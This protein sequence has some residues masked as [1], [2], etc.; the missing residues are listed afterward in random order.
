MIA[1][2]FWQRM[3]NQAHSGKET[4]QALVETAITLP[5]LVLLLLGAVELGRVAYAAVEVANSARAAAQYGAMNG[6]AIGD[7]NGMLN[8]AHADGYQVYAL[9]PASFTLQTSVS[10]VCANGTSPNDPTC[11]IPTDCAGSHLFTTL[12]VQTQATFDPLIHLS[13]FAPTFTLH[14]QSIQQVLQ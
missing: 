6:G 14:G 13:G 5:F 2:G 7:Y 8:A 12:T 4:G 3:V 1:R 9:N 10:C 11:L